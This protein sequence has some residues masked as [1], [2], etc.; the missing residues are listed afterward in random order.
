MKRKTP[1]KRT[2]SL[3]QNTGLKRTAKGR[4]KPVRKRTTTKG[5]KP[6]AWFNA[7]KPGSHGQTPA[8]KRLWRIVSETYRK[9]DFD[10]YGNQCPCCGSVFGHWRDGQ[11]G[12]WLRYSLCNSWFKYERVNLALICAGCNMKDDAVTLKKLGETLQ[13]RYGSEVL[14][15]IEHENQRYRGIKLETWKVVDYAARVAPHLVDYEAWNPEPSNK[16]NSSTLSP[17]SLQTN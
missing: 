1:L 6:P 3:R 7:V 15:Y 17:R 9:E 14:D 5:Y 11:L 8:Q 10:L 16:T 2:R 12:H 4:K 13:M